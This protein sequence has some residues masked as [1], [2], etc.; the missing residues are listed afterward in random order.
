MIKFAFKIVQFSVYHCIKKC[1]LIE[2]L[3][4]LEPMGLRICN[5]LINMLKDKYM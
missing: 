3:S 1:F 4:L 5:A 2:E